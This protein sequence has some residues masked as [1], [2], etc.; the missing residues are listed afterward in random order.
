MRVYSS[1]R[2][3]L[4]SASILTALACV[5][6]AVAVTASS[7][8]ASAGQDVEV[9]PPGQTLFNKSYDELTSEWSN[10][11]QKEPPD[12]SPAFDPDGQFCDLNQSGKIWFLAGTFGGFADRTCEVP[13]GVGVFFPIFAFV[14]WAPD[15]LNEEPCPEGLT[16]EVDL[17]R[18]DVNDD[19]PIAPD[20]D[21][22]VVVNGELVPDLYAYR[23]QSEA[24]GFTLEIGPLFEAFGVSPGPK[25]P[26]VADGYWILLD[27]LPPG[28]HTVSFSGDNGFGV[29]GVNWTLLVPARDGSVRRS[30]KR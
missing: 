28:E 21:L 4:E 14:S 5:A 10:W 3:L 1:L 16:E 8:I 26:A 19:I 7:S 9:V 6:V 13:A 11:L 20:A 25:S 27:K 30:A 12:T 15:F 17:I 22:E 29:G 24:G 23:S 2:R 18:C